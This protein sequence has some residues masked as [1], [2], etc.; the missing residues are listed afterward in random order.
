ME[1]SYHVSWRLD[2]DKCNS[3]TVANGDLLIGDKL[4]NLTCRYG[5]TDLIIPKMPYVCT[6]FSTGDDWLLGGHHIT[7]KFNNISDNSTVTVGTYKGNWNRQV[8]KGWNIST[9]FSLLTRGDTG[10]IN[11]SPRVIPTFN[12]RLQQGCNY[13][14]P[15]LVSDP[16]N[17]AIRCRWAVKD[18][19]RSVCKRFRGALLDSITCT[20]TY[21]TYSRIG[22]RAVAIMIEDFAPGSPNRPLSSVAL[23]FLVLVFKSNQPC[24]SLYI[25]CFKFPSIITHPSDEIVFWRQHETFNIMLTCMANETSS[26]YWEREIG[27]IPITS[28]GVYT[29]TITLIDVQPEDSGNYRC[30]AFVCSTS[31]R[32]FSNYA[33]VTISIGE[34]Y[35]YSSMYILCFNHLMFHTLVQI[36]V[37]VTHPSSEHINL[38][39]NATF[40][41]NATGYNVS[42]QW[43]IGSRSFPSKVTDINS[44]IL[45]IPDV[46][47]SDD[48]TY[49]C[50]ASNEVG[51]VTSKQ[52]KLIV[53]GKDT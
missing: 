6:D 17:D 51:N 38:T 18:E 52:A 7:H 43:T 8:G 41:C 50:V 5:C 31:Y 15:L 16:D 11:S 2:G 40:T 23:Q 12:L 34:S 44:N 35:L 20:I 48:N 27:D 25:E 26:Y 14:I 22:L 45:V 39:Q 42:Y 1:I 30:V 3:T 4:S 33:A 24:S 21:I 46:R 9:T 19:C 29:D 13:T 10:K 49:T 37:L 32:S 36:P 53:T 47:S 28:I